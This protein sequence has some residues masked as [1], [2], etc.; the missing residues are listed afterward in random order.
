M[1]KSYGLVWLIWILMFLVVE[2]LAVIDTGPGDTLSEWVW[3]IISHPAVY[4]P[5]AGFMIWLLLHFLLRLR[6]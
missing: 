3:K 1:S 2:I 5:F 4:F 6:A